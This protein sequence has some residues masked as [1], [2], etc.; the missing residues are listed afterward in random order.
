M[1]WQETWVELDRMKSIVEWHSGEWTMAE[2]CRE[3]AASLETGY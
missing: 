3:L 2:L 1:P